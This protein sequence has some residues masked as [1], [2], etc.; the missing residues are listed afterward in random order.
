MEEFTLLFMALEDVSLTSQPDKITWKWTQDGIY[1][2]ATAYECQFIGVMQRFPCSFI[3]KAQTEPR[4]KFFAW[5]ALHDRVL[6]ADNMLKKNWPCSDICSFCLCMFETTNHI[7]LECNFTEAVWNI[8]AGKFGLPGFGSLDHSEGPLGWM[9]QIGRVG[10]KREKR[11]KLGI[12]LTFW[13]MVWKERN[14]RIFE[15][16]HLSH[17]A[18]AALIQDSINLQWLAKGQLSLSS[19]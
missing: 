11:R 1:S 10:S 3:W 8:V 5:L 19:P 16:E 14:R 6:T 2:V 13:W 18:L 9:Q 12:L 17:Q 15:Q 4:S 7:L